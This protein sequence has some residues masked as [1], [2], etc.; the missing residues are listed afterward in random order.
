MR[1]IIQHNKNNKTSFFSFTF[2]ILSYLVFVFIFISLFFFFFFFLHRLKSRKKETIQ[3]KSR[4]YLLE[5]FAIGVPDNVIF[6]CSLRSVSKRNY[7]LT[8]ML[9]ISPC[10][11]NTVCDQQNIKA[12]SD[13]FSFFFF[14]STTLSEKNLFKV[15][16][17]SKK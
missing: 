15:F 7:L 17:K 5:I 12:L 10:A 4:F 2:N 13:F 14:L 16:S 8:L 3:I 11:S 9:S 6:R 1:S